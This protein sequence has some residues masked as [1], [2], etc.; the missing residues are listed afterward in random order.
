[1]AK[2]IFDIPEAGRPREKLQ[3]KGAEF[4]S[5]LELFA[6][7]LGSGTSKHDILAISKKIIKRRRS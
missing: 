2:R 6:I 5:D 4:L 3:R 7:L 1:M